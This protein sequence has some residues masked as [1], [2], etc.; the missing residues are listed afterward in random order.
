M[1]EFGWKDTDY[2]LL[3]AGTLAG[4]IV[5]CGPQCTGGNFTDWDT[6]PGWDDMGYPIAECFAGRHARSSPSRENTGGL[7][8]AGDRRRADPLRD[9]RPRRLRDARRGLRL[10]RRARS[11]TSAPT[12]SGS[13]AR[14]GRSPPDTYKVTVTHADGYRVMTTAM[15]SG[16]DA[17]RQGAPRGPCADRARR[18]ADRRRRPR[19]AHRVV[20][21]GDRRRRH[22]RARP[23]RRR[24]HRG[25]GEDRRRG[26][27]RRRR[28]RS[29]RPGVRADGARRRRA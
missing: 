28:W 9:R 1:H 22:V 21:R 15:F 23:P 2:D 5:E 14:R 8:S 4:H 17:A 24:R 13:A 10:A 27:R 3:S 29:S 11:S 16:I 26:T 7:V 12:A 19:A 20:G 6:V 25:G 18:A